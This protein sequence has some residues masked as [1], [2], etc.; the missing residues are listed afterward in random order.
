MLIG[1]IY[2]IR[3]NTYNHSIP[4]HKLGENFCDKFDNLYIACHN[5]PG[6]LTLAGSVENIDKIVKDAPKSFKVIIVDID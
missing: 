2:R 5:A 4:K 6:S 3:F 1:P